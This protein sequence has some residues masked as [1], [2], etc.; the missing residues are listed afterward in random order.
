MGHPG[1]PP[2]ETSHLGSSVDGCLPYPGHTGKSQSLSPGS[3]LHQTLNRASSGMLALPGACRSRQSCWK[4][5]PPFL[6][7]CS[8]GKRQ[9]VEMGWEKGGSGKRSLAG[10]GVWSKWPWSCM[11]ECSEE[12]MAVEPVSGEGGRGSAQEK[13]LAALGE[14]S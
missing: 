9:A 6:T 3:N 12:R 13:V 11:S 2:Q 5:V 7:L 8:R 4:Q 14:Q 10:L 1:R